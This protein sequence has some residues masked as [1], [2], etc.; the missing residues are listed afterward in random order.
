MKAY[1]NENIR[2]ITKTGSGSYCV[3]IPKEMIK[4]LNWKERQK[5]VIKKSGK[6][7]II[8]DWK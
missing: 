4:E 6:E 2:K 5:V 1:T 7:I 3:I 8:K